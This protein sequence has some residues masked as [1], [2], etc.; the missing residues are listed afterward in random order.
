MEPSLKPGVSATE[1]IR[2]Q[3]DRTVA[4]MGESARVY[5]TP[6]MVS[7]VESACLRLIQ[8]HLDEEQSSVGVPIQVDMGASIRRRIT[9]LFSFHGLPETRPATWAGCSPRSKLPT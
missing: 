8:I 9:A 7:D 2:I 1:R 6:S 3:T 4:F 5:S